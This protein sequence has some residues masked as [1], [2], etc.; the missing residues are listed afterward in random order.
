MERLILS[1]EIGIFSSRPGSYADKDAPTL[2]RHQNN[3]V[4]LVPASFKNEG[5]IDGSS[6]CSSRSRAKSDLP[7]PCTENSAWPSPAIGSTLLPTAPASS[8]AYTFRSHRVSHVRLKVDLGSDEGMATG[9]INDSDVIVQSLEVSPNFGEWG[10]VKQAA[11]DEDELA[12]EDWL[13]AA[14]V[15]D[16]VGGSESVSTCNESVLP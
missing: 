7:T 8:A 10:G 16:L 6:P 12:A 1:G 13:D 3:E 5:A 11:G 2:R 14:N 9:A 4:L 15:L